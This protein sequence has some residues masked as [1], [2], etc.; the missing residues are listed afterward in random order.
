MELYLKGEAKT[1]GHTG[2]AECSQATD[3]WFNLA[4]ACC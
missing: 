3:G 1:I 4:G 2:I